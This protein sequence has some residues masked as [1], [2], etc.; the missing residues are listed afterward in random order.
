MKVFVEGQVI[1]RSI[2]EG[3]GLLTSPS[4]ITDKIFITL[5]LLSPDVVI[6]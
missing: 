5:S 6:Y 3:E 4:S 2:E 1:T